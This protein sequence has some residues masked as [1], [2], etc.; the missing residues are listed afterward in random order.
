MKFFNVRKSFMET[1]IICHIYVTGQV[2]KS[3]IV[4]NALPSQCA[5]Y[6][7]IVHIAWA[8]YVNTFA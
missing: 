7:G 2:R 4:H 1:A 8:K 6:L 3:G 5:K